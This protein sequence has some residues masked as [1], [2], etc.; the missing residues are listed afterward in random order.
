MTIYVL[1]GKKKGGNMNPITITC[2]EAV[3][4]FGIPKGTLANLRCQKKG[5]RFFKVG[6]RVVYRVEDFER[7][8]MSNPCLT[9]DQMPSRED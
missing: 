2:D 1:N 5:C 8:V 9:I 6:K 3:K 4:L 7:W